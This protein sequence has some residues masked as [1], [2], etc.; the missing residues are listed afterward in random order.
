MTRAKCAI[1]MKN[2]EI[3]PTAYEELLPYAGMVSGPPVPAFFMPT[4]RLLADLASDLGRTDDAAAHYEATLALCRKGG[5]R[6]E[7]VLT[8]YQYAEMLSEAAA[9]ADRH[10]A[11]ALLREGLQVA[12]TIG[13]GR[14]QK[15][16]ADLDEKL[17]AGR[18]V[19]DRYPDG[20]TAREVEVLRELAAGKSNREIAEALFI[21]QNTVIRHIANIFS[22]TGSA[23]RALAAVYAAEHKLQ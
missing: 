3:E 8:C 10:K 15:Q 2:V 16:L 1:V 5:F 21:S 14:L 13:M 23:N 17:A 22:K 9:D 6:T 18:Q 7:L 20:L 19:R 11:S 12:E 4:D